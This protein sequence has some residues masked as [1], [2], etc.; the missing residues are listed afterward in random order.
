M[1]SPQNLVAGRYAL[2]EVLGVGGMATVFAAD[3]TRLGRPVAV[4]VLKPELAANTKF[5]DR[6]K[7]E[8]RSVSA[9]THPAIVAVLD[10]GDDAYLDEAGVSHPRSFL[11]MERV[12]GLE[13]TALLER[14]PLKVDE[15][16][17]VA[18]DL[19][20]A[21]GFAHR[22]GIVHRDLKPSNIMLTSSGAIKVLDF[23]IARAVSETFD[24]LAQTTSIL[25]TAAYFSPEQARGE[26][27]DA[28][29]DVYAI[30]II[31]FEM[32]TGRTPFTADTAVGQAHQHLHMIP[33]APSTLNPKVSP[34]LDLVVA[35]ALTKNRDLRYQTTEDFARELSEAAAGRVPTPPVVLDDVDLL[36]APLTAT[37]SAPLGQPVSPTPAPRAPRSRR[38]RLIAGIVLAT[39]ILGV[40]GGIGYWVITLKPFDFSSHATVTVPNLSS[41]SY[42][43]AVGK[44]TA[45]E[46][47]PTQVKEKNETVPEGLVIRTDPA[48]GDVVDLRS[49][50]RVYVSAGKPGSPIPK[51]DGKSVA[52]A[53]KILTDAG[54]VLGPQSSTT[55]PTVAADTVLGTTPPSGTDAAPGSSVG[56]TVSNGKVELPLL[57]GKSVTEATAILGGPGLRLLPT[58]TADASC[59]REAEPTVHTQSLT[60]GPVPQGAALTLTYCSG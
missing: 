21:V 47:V 46:F 30:G 8:A 14:G 2:G 11:V 10:A 26:T 41:E 36:F 31:L 13:L 42:N 24:D 20:A 28:R 60:P 32:L 35:R 7:Q 50:V 1:T 29:T 44:L 49:N 59:T 33:V 17:R 12:S 37:A 40:I 53:T 58:I 9:L 55:S 16:I 19:L 52:E 38:R 39:L 5:T 45:L 34:A 4:K 18:N 27:V 23:G 25:G 48:A 51:V 57:T 43:A 54:F 3:D 56:L 15:A 22:H 6:F